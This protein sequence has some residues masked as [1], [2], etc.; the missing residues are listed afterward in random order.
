MR[1]A[2]DYYYHTSVL[3]PMLLPCCYI[4]A[5]TERYARCRR[6]DATCISHAVVKML[7]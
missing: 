5:D 6:A 7:R 3:L 2:A 1:Y 4:D